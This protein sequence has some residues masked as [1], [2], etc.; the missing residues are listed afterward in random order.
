MYII[1]DKLNGIIQKRS[2]KNVNLNSELVNSSI[3]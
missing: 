2:Q 3:N 1:Q